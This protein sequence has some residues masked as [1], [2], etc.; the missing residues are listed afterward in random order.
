MTRITNDEVEKFRLNFSNRLTVTQL[1]QVSRPRTQHSVPGQGSN[2]D[3]S[4]RSRAHCTDL[5]ATV[6]TENLEKKTKKKKENV[7]LTWRTNV[8]QFRSLDAL[9][10]NAEER[11]RRYMNVNTV[12]LLFRP[13]TSKPATQSKW[14]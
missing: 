9:L 7:V 12:E 14:L 13:N 2:Q 3:P 8:I 1:L 6:G 4:L 11:K 5:E 10:I